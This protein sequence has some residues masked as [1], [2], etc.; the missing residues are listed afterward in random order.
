MLAALSERPHA[1]LAGHGEAL[2]EVPRRGLALVSARGDRTEDPLRPS[3][4]R[5]LLEPH[6]ALER[7][8]GRRVGLVQPAGCQAGFGH[9]WMEANR[10][11]WSFFE[12]SVPNS[13]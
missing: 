9:R 5:A 8:E 12:F 13:P 10:F 11:T 2:P 7:V 6:R 1:E 4:P 3:P